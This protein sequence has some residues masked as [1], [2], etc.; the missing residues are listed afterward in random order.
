[1]PFYIKKA[2]GEKELFDI[3]KFRNS[4][5]KT[6]A[7]PDLID[8]IAVEIQK[9][10][11][12]KSTKEIYRYA[13]DYLYNVNPSLAARYNIKR[14]LI[15]LGPA[16]FPFEQFIAK[17]FQEQNYTVESN[18]VVAGWCV[19]HEL[20][21]VASK[22]GKVSMIECKFHTRQGLK[23]DV[24]ITLYIDA[25]FHDIQK[26]WKTN[27]NYKQ[28]FN[29][30]WLTTNTKF[31]ANAIKYA[32][33]VGIK[34]LGWS[35][36]KHNNLPDLITKLGLYPITA[37]TSLSKK[38]KRF[39]IKNDLVLCR[40]VP[41]HENLLKQLSFTP[42]HIKKLIAEATGTCKINNL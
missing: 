19:E 23:T 10:S 11:P 33:C 20:D 26:A 25:R 21:I 2:S 42:H 41:Y 5:K 39:L 9:L 18:Q 14:A 17:L 7:P 28:T 13:L 34:L 8:K 32:T 4:L 35:Y 24:K 6:G 15:E 38:Q 37:L 22:E 31:T 16:G 1:M 30:V 3:Q 29:Q 27:P 36:P 12:I 40:D